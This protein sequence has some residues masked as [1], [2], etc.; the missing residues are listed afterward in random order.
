MSVDTYAPYWHGE[1]TGALATFVSPPAYRQIFDHARPNL[2]TV[3]DGAVACIREDLA[4]GEANILPVI[5]CDFGTI[6]TAKLYGGKVIPPPENGNLHIEPVVQVPEQL[7]GLAP[8]PFEESDF[9]L[10]VDLHRLVCDRLETDQVFVRTPDFQGPMNTLALVMDHEELMVGMYTEPDAIHAALSGI[11]DTLIDYHRRLRR[12]L[13]GGKVI[14]NIWPFTFLPE[15]LGA[16]ITQDMMPL[17]SPDLYREF[18]IP[19]LRR[20]AEAFNGVQIHCCGRYGQHL[21]AL[22]ELGPLVRGLEFH[23]PFTPFAEMHAMFGDDIVYIPH[24]FGECNDYADYVA[25]A[26]DLLRQGTGNTRFWFAQ[27][28]GWCDELELRN[29]VAAR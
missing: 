18:E 24:L 17:L 20:I 21:T 16:S 1:Q 3:A 27:A 13:G 7:A 9:Q 19:H 25:F 22:R 28:K 23:H 8:C 10:A 4:S 5:Y 14:G 11:T 6:S 15:D 26:R 2:Q 12:K 29:V